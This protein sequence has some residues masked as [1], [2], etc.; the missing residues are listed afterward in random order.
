M[1]EDTIDPTHLRYQAQTPTVSMSLPALAAAQTSDREGSDPGIGYATSDERIIMYMYR[2]L[3]RVRA[4]GVQSLAERAL[5]AGARE[6]FDLLA[7]ASETA[8][9]QSS[10]NLDTRSSELPTGASQDPTSAEASML[11]NPPID[12]A[13]SPSAAA[14]SGATINN[15]SKPRGRGRARVDSKNR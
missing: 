7:R 13:K 3:T 5:L 11:G 6:T 15:P 14:S 4:T 12:D 8:L 1:F 9:K 2:L 10:E